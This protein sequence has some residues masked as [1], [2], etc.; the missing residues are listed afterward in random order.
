MTWGSC[1]LA[2]S[3][4]LDDKK[5]LENLGISSWQVEY[6]TRFRDPRC[7]GYLTDGA[8][9]VLKITAPCNHAWHDG[10]HHEGV[11]VGG[12]PLVQS[13]GRNSEVKEVHGPPAT[14]W[15]PACIGRT[16]FLSFS[17]PFPTLKAWSLNLPSCFC[18]LHNLCLE[19]PSPVLLILN[20]TPPWVRSGGFPP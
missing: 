12:C 8:G 3:Q 17:E 14:T 4:N 7:T 1:K 2:T 9:D 19:R 6:T 5:S 18:V 16:L 15:L 20:L 10:V 11:E 13:Y